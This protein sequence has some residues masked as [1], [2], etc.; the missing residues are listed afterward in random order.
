MQQSYKS[1]ATVINSWNNSCNMSLNV[2]CLAVL[3]QNDQCASWQ[4]ANRSRVKFYA[5]PR[6]Y[7]NTAGQQR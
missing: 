1:D 7:I 2:S 4:A 3:F 6:L 5:D